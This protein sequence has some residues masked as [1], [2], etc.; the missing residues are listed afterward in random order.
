MPLNLKQKWEKF[1]KKQLLIVL[2]IFLLAFGVR[3]HLMKY[4]LIFEF[5][6]YWHARM[7]SYIIQTGTVPPLDPLAYYQIG[8]APTGSQSPVFWYLSAGI[9]KFATLGGLIGGVYNKDLWILFVKIL[10]ALYGA[11]ICVGMYFLFKEIYDKKAG[12]VAG[13]VSATVP[14]FVY[15]TMA[16]FFEDDSLGFLWLVLGFYFL[17]KAL[18][19]PMLSKEHYKNVIIS[20]IFFGIMA[21]TWGMFLII[22]IVMVAYLFLQAIIMFLRNVDKKTIKSFV[23]LWVISMAIFTGFSFALKG[24]TWIDS[25]ATY[26]KQYAPVTQENI[27]RAEGRGGNDVISQTVGEENTGRQFFGTKYNA[28]I[29]FPLLAIP[30]V[31]WRMF[32]KKNDYVSL[33]VLIWILLTLFMAWNKLKFTY[34]LGLPVAAGAAIVAAELFDFIKNRNKIEKQ[35]AALGLFFMIILG[36]ASATMFMTQQ[37][38][39]IES[40]LGWKPALYWMKDN[41]PVGSKFFNWWDEGHWITFIGERGAS[42]DNRNYDFEADM[43]VAKF[44]IWEGDEEAAFNIVKGYKSDYV[45][46]SDDLLG[47]GGALGIYAYNTTNFSDPRLARYFGIEFYCEEKVDSLSKQKS[48]SCGPNTLTEQQM[49]QGTYIQWNP[50]SNQLLNGQMP[51]FIY[52]AKDNSRLFILNA[53][54]NKTIGARLWFNDPTITR[55]TQVY[56]NEGV[57][58]FKVNY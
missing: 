39:N 15:R 49:L 58:I 35:A 8:G 20:G 46:L 2:A 19:E 56:S 5:D 45:I 51:A 27:Q 7:V 14:A 34:T 25:A 28:L 1:D 50:N 29:L 30:L 47:K 11:L 16:G 23:V 31:L 36:V 54:T 3:A 44:I 53:G 13:V 43:N 41:T 33:F 12:I 4:D 37:V 24:T 38:P 32:R 21:W 52:R 55:F 57:K 18:K 9:Y 42:T 17:V 26:I 6:S 10:P 40:A 48:Y 22:P